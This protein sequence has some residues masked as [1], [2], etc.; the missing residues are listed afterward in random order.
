[1]RQLYFVVIKKFGTKV[2]NIV[3]LRLYKEGMYALPKLTAALLLC[4]MVV[5][6]TAAS[7][8]TTNLLCAAPLCGKIGDTCVD[9]QYFCA[10]HCLSSHCFNTSAGACLPIAPYC[11]KQT[12]ANCPDICKRY[13]VACGVEVPCRM[14]TTESACRM[15]PNCSWRTT[16]CV[17]ANCLQQTTKE[18]CTQNSCYWTSDV[19]VDPSFSQ[20]TCADLTL[21]KECALKPAACSWS[22]NTQSCN[23][24]PSN[25]TIDPKSLPCA[26]MTSSSEMCNLNPKCKWADE[27]CADRECPSFSAATCPKDRCTF[28]SSSSLCL[29]PCP[30]ALPFYC[31]ATKTCAASSSSCKRC[32][33]SL[34]QCWDSSCAENYL[35]CPCSP[36][37]PIRCATLECVASAALCE[38]RCTDAAPVK[39]FDNTCVKTAAD[40][41]CASGYT[42]C[43]D[44]SCVKDAL[45]C[46]K[47]CAATMTQC[48]DKSCAATAAECPCSPNTPL[49][50]A[51]G[52]CRQNK[53]YCPASSAELCARSA[54]P[55]LKVSSA[56][57]QADVTLP[58][59]ITASAY[60]APCGVISSEVLAIV[61]SVEGLGATTVNTLPTERHDAEPPRPDDT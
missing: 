46:S 30:A 51:D 57:V 38:V 26:A 61:W 49:R 43:D 18:T 48:W 28:D 31:N 36:Q 3:A 37:L 39:C 32:S 22:A 11:M 59:R 8:C 14:S 29:A 1:M 15:A 60:M 33:S 47:V 55:I 25:S 4:V 34:V 7:D 53:T 9:A 45:E 10:A 19:C 20:L 27:T 35:R 23:V 6:S 44:K 17:K 42:R 21:P 56:D 40:C 24:L 52:T 16:S 58:F 12:A 13:G 50:C 54:V 41:P 5:W 2:E